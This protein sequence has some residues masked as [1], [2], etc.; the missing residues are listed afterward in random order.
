MV[1]RTLA[2]ALGGAFAVTGLVQPAAAQDTGSAPQ[3]SMPIACEIGKTC[4]VQNYVDIDPGPAAQDFACGAATYQG[5]KGTDFRLLSVAETAK[6]IAVIAS[7]DGTVK[8]LRDGMEDIFVS[9]GGAANIQNRECGNGVVLDHGQ[10]WETQYCHM[11]KGSVAVKPGDGV[12]RGQRL[13]DTGFSGA[14]DFAHVHLQVRHNAQVLD[15]FTG[16]PQNAV[17]LKDKTAANGLWRPET[18]KILAYATNQ[19]LSAGFTGDL[20]AT[21]ALEQQHNPAAPTATSPHFVF[22]ARFMNLRAGDLVQMSVKGP[23]NFSVENPGKPLERDKATWVSYAGKKL[24][25][26]G[27]PAGR[28]TGKATVVRD[29]KSIAEISADL[30]LAP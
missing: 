8:S 12:T 13:G 25:A 18:A 20:P 17:C 22:F 27:W 23:Q 30:D 16:Q 28:Y 21:N 10:G 7:A 1:R 2:I 15:P 6:H 4:F 29:G 3:L 19:P 14:A 24:T 26:A 11:L 9:Q 5:H